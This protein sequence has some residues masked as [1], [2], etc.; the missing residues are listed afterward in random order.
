ML[1]IFFT[2]V[3]PKKIIYKGKSSMFVVGKLR[4][5]LTHIYLNIFPP[6]SVSISGCPIHKTSLD[7]CCCCGFFFFLSSQKK[8]NL[9][10]NYSSMYS[11]STFAFIFSTAPLFLPLPLHDH[12]LYYKVCLTGPFWLNNIREGLS[13]G[14]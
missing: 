7:C 6:L 2:V 8:W 5:E 10:P 9:T 14:R 3:P 13:S 4:L 12:P 1:L 11:F